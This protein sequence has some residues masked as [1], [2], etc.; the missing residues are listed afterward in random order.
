MTPPTITLGWKT[1]QEQPTIESSKAWKMRFM[2][3]GQGQF[4]VTNMLHIDKV[5][6][7]E[8]TFDL[9]QFM[10]NLFVEFLLFDNYKLC[11]GVGW[12]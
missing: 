9:D 4:T 8:F 2:P 10:T 7:H 12:Q 3:Y 5:L 6:H 11:F 1:Y